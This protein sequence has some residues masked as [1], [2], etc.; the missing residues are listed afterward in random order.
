[1]MKKKKKKVIEFSEPVWKYSVGNE[2]ED[3]VEYNPPRSH[4]CYNEWIEYKNKWR[5][6]QEKNAG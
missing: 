1:M 5:E 6:K 2:G 4:P 3:W